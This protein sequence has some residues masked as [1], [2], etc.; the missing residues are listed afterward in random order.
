MSPSPSS[1]YLKTRT[2]IMASRL[3]GNDELETLI[4]QPLEQLGSEFSL[5]SL[6]QK[7]LSE[8]SLNRAAERSMIHKLMDD[9]SILLRPLDAAS[10]DFLVHWARKFELYNL[11]ALIRGKLQH[12][13]YDQ[14]RENLYELPLLI[15]LPHDQLLRTESVPELLRRLERTP[16]S[17]IAR[18]ARQVY[19]EKN[20]PFSLDATIDQRFYTGLLKRARKIHDPDRQP[21]LKL[22]GSLIDQQNLPWILRYRFNYK[23]SPSETF[24]LLIPSGTHLQRDRLITLVKL[25]SFAEVMAALPPR[26]AALMEDVATPMETEQAMLQETRQIALEILGFSSSAIACSLAYLVIREQDL[27]RIYAIVQG[28]SLALDEALIRQAADM[29]PAQEPFHV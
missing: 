9:L 20:E 2:A 28:K 1:T 21:L 12:L 13:S 26:L 7:N 25:E 8:A 3:L 14:I 10:R 5:E 24:Y 6:L 15:S 16:Y 27:K 17:D 4:R 11:K 19:E 23:L 29:K 18:Q 22:L